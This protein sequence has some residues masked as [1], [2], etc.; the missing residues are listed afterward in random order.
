[1]YQPANLPGLEFKTTES[2]AFIIN[3]IAVQTYINNFFIQTNEINYN[4]M[5]IALQSTIA[6]TLQSSGIRVLV[7]DASGTVA[8]DSSKTN[9]TWEAYQSKSI[10]DNH[11]TRPEI[12]QALLSFSGVGSSNRYSTSVREVD[13]YLA[14]RFGLSVTYPL[15]CYR[16]SQPV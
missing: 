16:L 8:F 9:N 7:T 13:L 12:L 11:N 15:G 10:N 1:M 2:L 5:V 6:A 4:L 14:T 3:N